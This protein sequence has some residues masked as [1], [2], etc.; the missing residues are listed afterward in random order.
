MESIAIDAKTNLQAQTQK[1]ERVQDRLGQI[2]QEA[3]V[4]NR[5]LGEIK[6]AR[7]V[8]KMI[9]YGVLATIAAALLVVVVVKFA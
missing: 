1:M 4:A 2:N 3:N 9:L 6:K 7:A 8:N 5:Q